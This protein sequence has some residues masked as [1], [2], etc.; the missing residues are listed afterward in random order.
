MTQLSYICV[1]YLPIYRLKDIFDIQEKNRNKL[2]SIDLVH[3][4]EDHQIKS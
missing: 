1:I 2:L 3:E 4:L